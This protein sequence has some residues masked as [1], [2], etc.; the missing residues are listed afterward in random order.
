M[1]AMWDNVSF[2]LDCWIGFVF[3]YWW[4][5]MLLM[6]D[7]VHD[8]HDIRHTDV[9]VLVHIR[10]G[11]WD[12]L[13]FAEDVVDKLHDISHAHLAVVVDVAFDARHLY[14]FP[15]EFPVVG[16]H[17]GAAAALGHIQRGIGVVGESIFRD[18]QW[19]R[20]FHFHGSQHITPIE[21]ILAN[22]FHLRWDGDG[23][24]A[25]A[26]GKSTSSNV[27]HAAGD[28]EG[29]QAGAIRESI[30]A[31]ARHAVRNSD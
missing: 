16:G 2:L 21:S 9:A 5:M 14:D 24:Q 25:S 12:A 18:G 26:I 1:R 23:L 22:G 7:D 19:F 20:T 31:D 8:F 17:V 6:E 28:G 10:C 3:P 4:K 11:L 13:G 15:E 30:R 29:S 27:G